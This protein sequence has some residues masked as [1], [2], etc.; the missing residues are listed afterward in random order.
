MTVTL[1]IGGARSGKSSLAVARALDWQRASNALRQAEAEAEAVVEAGVVFV[2]TGSA[3]D[4]EMADR[5]T[6]HQA[7][8]PASWATI[9]APV[10]LVAGLRAACSLSSGVEAG[11]EAGGGSR[12]DSAVGVGLA[13]RSGVGLRIVSNAGSEVGPG[14]GLGVDSGVG[15]S[16]DSGVGLGRIVRLR[17]EPALIIDCLSLWVANHLMTPMQ[18]PDELDE[19]EISASED[20]GPYDNPVDVDWVGVEEELLRQV[21]GCFALLRDRSAPTWF[22]TN[23]VGLSLVPMNVMGRRYRDILGR[24]NA[25][26]SLLADEAFLT[27]AG[28]VLRLERP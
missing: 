7:E 19:E 5:I 17:P 13:M 11:S 27:V 22:V 28:R 21:D 3:G 15:L 18:P 16:V 2:A 1:F 25:K 8:R 24:V 10:D 23:E 26:V 9:E 6:R 14:V 12:A 4:G 20:A